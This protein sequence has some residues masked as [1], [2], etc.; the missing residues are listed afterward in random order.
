[1]FE[2]DKSV[3]AM[4]VRLDAEV[5]SRIELDAVS[6]ADAAL[7]IVKHTVASKMFDASLLNSHLRFAVTLAKAVPML[8]IRYPRKKAR[9]P[10][11][12]N[13]LFEYLEEQKRG[14]VL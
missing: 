9:L 4:M 13:A 11:I 2:L 10:D 8:R 1:M 12:R 5:S 14:S 3:P 6:K 7:E